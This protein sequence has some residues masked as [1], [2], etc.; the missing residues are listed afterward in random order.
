MAPAPAAA[1]AGAVG[2]IIKQNRLYPVP[3][4]GPD[5]PPD[6]KKQG[7]RGSVE[8]AAVCR[9]PT[10]AACGCRAMPSLAPPTHP[11]RPTPGSK[12]VLRGFF[13]AFLATFAGCLL[14]YTIPDAVAAAM[15]RVMP[16]WFYEGQV[17][18]GLGLALGAGACR[19]AAMHA[20]QAACGLHGGVAA[21]AVLPALTLAAWLRCAPA[22]AQTMLLAIGTCTFNYLFT[23]FTK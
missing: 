3:K 2:N 23:G 6:E 7:A 13:L 10:A 9:G 14:S 8:G 11:P 15:G 20:G 5:S 22:P 19:R 16:V 21:C 4:G 17:R 12:N 1:L 18:C